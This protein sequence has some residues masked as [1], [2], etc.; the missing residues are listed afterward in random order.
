MREQKNINKYYIIL[1]F[2]FILQKQRVF[3]RYYKSMASSV[4]TFGTDAGNSKKILKNKY[5]LINERNYKIA[6]NKIFNISKLKK[7]N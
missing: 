3:K 4:I 7:K 6:A 5:F 1:D 2:I